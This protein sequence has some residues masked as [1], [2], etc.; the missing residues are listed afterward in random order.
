MSDMHGVSEVNGVQEFKYFVD[1]EWRT[2]ESNKLFDV[3]R[4][5]DRKL[6][7]RVAEVVAQKRR[8]QST[9][10]PKP[11]RRGPRRRPPNAPGCSS[12][13]PK[14][15]SAAARRSRRFLHLRPGARFP[16]RRFSKTLSPPRSSKRRVGCICQRARFW[17]PISRVHTR[18]ACA[19]HSAWSHASRRGTVRTCCPG[20]RCSR[21]WPLVTP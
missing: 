9:L 4:P 6:Y 5:Y 19:G 13:R 11:S 12:R 2:A 3:Y 15:S 10:P 16:S 1:G 8:E 18:S 17:R 20:G 7:A 14:S 21:P